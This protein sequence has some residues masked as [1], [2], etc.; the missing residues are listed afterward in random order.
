[1]TGDYARNKAIRM[2]EMLRVRT[3][4]R[5][6]TPAEAEQAAR[7]A[8]RIMKRYNLNGDEQIEANADIEPGTNK[9]EGWAYTLM[10]AIARRFEVKAS[11]RE[12]VGHKSVVRFTGPE[13]RIAVA[14]WLFLAIAKDLNKRSHI[15]G[16]TAGLT[17]GKFRSFRLQFRQA[18]A[19]AILRRFF[20]DPFGVSEVVVSDEERERYAKQRKQ[21]EEREKK[22]ISKMSKKQRMEQLKAELLR[23]HAANS[24]NQFGNE[25]AIDTN[26]VGGKLVANIEHQGSEVN[27]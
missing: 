10:Q 6:A 8:D 17:G 25:V 12:V 7:M 26:A 18:A 2:L 20:D 27:R 22:R 4:A 5:G 13:H 11:Y 14:K 9:V 23:R 3:E 16:R 21:Q 24:G 19:F 15:E 1:M